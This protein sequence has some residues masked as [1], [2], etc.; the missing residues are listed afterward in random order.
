MA[1]T[2]RSSC[3]QSCLVGDSCPTPQLA[4]LSNVFPAQDLPAQWQQLG[5]FEFWFFRPG[6]R[7]D[8][9]KYFT[10]QPF[11]QF[12]LGSFDSWAPSAVCCQLW[13]RHRSTSRP[14]PP[15]ILKPLICSAQAKYFGMQT[16]RELS[17]FQN[18]HYCPLSLFD[19]Y[20]IIW[21]F[22]LVK[23]ALLSVSQI[24]WIN[25]SLSFIIIGIIALPMLCSYFSEAE[26]LYPSKLPARPSKI[27]SSQP[28]IHFFMSNL[29]L[30]K[31]GNP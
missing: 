3:G 18:C 14:Q 27:G 1:R 5:A 16:T 9:V 28:N 10:H 6:Q 21:V 26:W 19:C 24:H 7:G 11:C 31:S 4:A 2:Q 30:S 22:Q 29:N 17:I 8:V 15:D 25:I 13:L 12:G 20:V 23:Q